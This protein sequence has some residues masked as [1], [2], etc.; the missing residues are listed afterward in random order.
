M[1]EAIE[2]LEDAVQQARE[3]FD[4]CADADYESGYIPNEEMQLLIAMDEA[5]AK[6]EII[7]RSNQ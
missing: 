6:L 5:L 4:D 7:K 3:Y 2:I 1:N